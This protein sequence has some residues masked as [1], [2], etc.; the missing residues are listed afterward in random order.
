MKV[1]V[2]VQGMDSLPEDK[3]LV[4]HVVNA[5]N[6]QEVVQALQGRSD[7]LVLYLMPSCPAERLLKLVEDYPGH[8]VCYTSVELDPVLHSRFARHGNRRPVR[9]SKESFLPSVRET[10][11]KELR[12]SL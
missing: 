2:Y 9:P 1:L 8:V 7:E 12:A 5:N 3:R 11:L 6:W 4:A 10:L